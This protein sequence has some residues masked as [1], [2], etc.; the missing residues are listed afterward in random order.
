MTTFFKTVGLLVIAFGLLDLGLQSYGISI[1]RILGIEVPRFIGR[2]S[3]LF[4]ISYGALTMFVAQY[5]ARRP[6]KKV[7]VIDL[8][9][10]FIMADA[11]YMRPE[12]PAP[13]FRVE[14]RDI[15]RAFAWGSLV[16][17]A[18]LLIFIR[19]VP[20]VST[21]LF[22]PAALAPQ[23]HKLLVVACVL[24]VLI[25][26]LYGIFGLK[27]RHS[28]SVTAMLSGV[29]ITGLM[30][31]VSAASNPKL[32]TTLYGPAI[33]AQAYAA[34]GHEDGLPDG[35]SLEGEIISRLEAA[36]RSRRYAMQRYFN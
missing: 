8:S 9:D 14:L 11:H 33:M 27:L 12:P 23:T 4:E 16:I 10:P 17:L 22:D 25:P 30:L 31:T 34:I 36:S 13:S 19:F 5:L 21:A 20:G 26:L 18:F 32:A 28:L 2:N 7:E 24:T 35:W 1:H 29:A 15:L 3:Y 6:Q